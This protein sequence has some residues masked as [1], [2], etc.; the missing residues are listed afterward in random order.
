MGRLQNKIAIVTGAAQGMGEAISRR[1]VAEGAR[2]ALCDINLDATEKLV[3][4]LGEGAIA[5]RLD[6][7]D[8]DDWLRVVALARSSFGCV[9]ILVNNAGITGPTKGLL[10]LDEEDF[11]KVCSVNQTGV[12]L[13]MRAVVP[14]I[15][16]DGGG[17]IVNISSISG[18]LANYGTNNAA[19][20]AS[21]FAVRGLTKFAAIE[22]AER[23]I[24]VNSVH[25]G[26]T[27]TP[28]L[29]ASLNDEQI[30]MAA[31][32]IPSKRVCE[33]EEIA[34]LVVFLASDEAPYITGNEHII[35]GGYTIV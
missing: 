24:R 26:Y 20:A 11:L 19:Y 15:L 31:K 21:K 25:P 2:V 16:E 12:F 18:L 30:E 13:G 6:V 23:N 1:F 32:N 33:P 27:R 34:N 5:A 35:D 17:A 22:F 28:M 9:N 14:S 29:T 10:D 3:A 7:S 8:N 4:E